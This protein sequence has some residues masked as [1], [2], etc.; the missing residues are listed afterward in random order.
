MPIA[1]FS[2]SSG[3]VLRSSAEDALQHP[4]GDHERDRVR[5]VAGQADRR[6][7]EAEADDAGQE[8]LPVPE[9]VADLAD[10]DQRDGQGQ[11]VAVG[12]PLNVGER[13]AEVALDG[14]VGDRDDR[15]V[16]CHHHDPERGGEQRQ[17]GAA[18]HAL[19]PGERARRALARGDV[20]LM[21]HC[22]TP[23]RSLT[24]A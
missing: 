15:A 14:R 11:Q 12:H 2:F 23:C 21:T 8:D 6:G 5:D 19:P 7:R 13:R 16:E 18:A 24:S 3:N 20:D 1:L 9:P 17:P 10:G 4:E 22:G